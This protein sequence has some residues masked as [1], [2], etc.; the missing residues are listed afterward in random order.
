MNFLATCRG[1]H[2]RHGM[3]PGHDVALQIYKKGEA[4][5]YSSLASD[6]KISGGRA[7]VFGAKARHVAKARSQHFFNAKEIGER[8][9][10]S[11]PWCLIGNTQKIYMLRRMANG[12]DVAFCKVMPRT[13]GETSIIT[14]LFATVESQWNFVYP[15]S[16]ASMNASLGG[17]DVVPIAVVVENR[18]DDHEPVHHRR[19]RRR[20]RRRRLY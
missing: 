18:D 15:L 19:R 11:E 10:P 16:L 17:L 7:V 1:L 12:D 20:R 13:S 14:D 3:M 6:E 8:C 5:A 9:G 4:I 2:T